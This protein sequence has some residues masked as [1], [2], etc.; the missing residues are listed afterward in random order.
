MSQERYDLALADLARDIGLDAAALT[1][2]QELVIDEIPIALSYEPD[3]MGGAM[4]GACYVGT[5]SISVDASAELLQILLQANTLG[6]ATFRA[7]LGMQRSGR[8]VMSRRMP[9]DTP[10]ER[11]AFALGEL[12]DASAL[13]AQA[14]DEGLENRA[15]Q[16]LMSQEGSS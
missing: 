2:Y 12:A 8:L 11:L 9:L 13:W 3:E 10:P 15:R 5:E 16:I 7:T 6:P 4:Q 14:L 1:K